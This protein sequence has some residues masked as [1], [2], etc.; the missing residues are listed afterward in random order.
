MQ[1][2]SNSYYPMLLPDGDTY[3]AAAL[4][5]E[6]NQLPI[7][8]RD[9]L[10]S[11]ELPKILMRIQEDYGFDDEML[12]QISRL[13]RWLFFQKLTWEEFGMRVESV[14]FAS[15]GKGDRLNELLERIRREILSMNPTQYTDPED[16]ADEESFLSPSIDPK[17]IRYLPILKALSEYPELHQQRITTEKIIVKGEREPVAP[18]VR[19]WLRVYRD[20]LGVGQHGSIER[21]QFLFQGTNTKSLSAAEREIVSTIIKS[22][23]EEEPLAIDTQKKTLIFQ[24]ATKGQSA[25]PTPPAVPIPRPSLTPRPVLHFETGPQVPLQGINHAPIEGEISFSSGQELP[26]ERASGNR[27]EEL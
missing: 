9:I 20:E 25:A 16:N 23:D 10:T 17:L 2:D 1:K 21:G 11:Q 14:L 7:R 8:F 5:A 4:W 22:L 24:L 13:L 18:T 3:D 15:E 19:N 12:A 6:F 27:R 26:G